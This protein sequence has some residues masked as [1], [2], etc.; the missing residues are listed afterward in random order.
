MLCVPTFLSG[1]AGLQSHVTQL[2]SQAAKSQES[3]KKIAAK[4]QESSR[5]VAA[6]SQESSS[7]VASEKKESD[8][9]MSL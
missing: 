8:K 9:W 5:K 4:L 3:G 1:I 6:K 7:E 2:G